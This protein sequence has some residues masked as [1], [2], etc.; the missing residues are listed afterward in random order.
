MC[1]RLTIPFL[2]FVVELHASM[3]SSYTKEQ[4]LSES[5]L[6]V[7]GRLLG[8]EFYQEDTRVVNVVDGREFLLEDQILTDWNILILETLKGHCEESEMTFTSLGGTFGGKSQMSTMDFQ[9][10]DGSV[11]LF[12]LRW[13][14]RNKKWRAPGATNVFLVED[15]GRSNKLKTT[16]EMSFGLASEDRGVK[17]T[18]P[19]LN[20]ESLEDFEGRMPG[21]VRLTR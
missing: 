6:V 16:G 8:R 17:R 11:A 20:A 19:M 5:D 9:L 13:D 15:Y 14:S 18:G 10:N 12:F 21:C 7:L 1:L 3:V 2:I 4:I